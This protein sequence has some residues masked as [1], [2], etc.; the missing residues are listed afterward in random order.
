MEED[1]GVSWHAL[2]GRMAAMRAGQRGFD[3]YHAREPCRLTNGAILSGRERTA[4]KRR[5]RAVRLSEWLAC[6]LSAMA[7]RVHVG[8]QQRVH[9]RLV[10]TALRPKPLNDI[11]IDP[12]RK[13]CFP[14]W[15]GET[16][17]YHS[18]RE[19]FRC[20]FGSVLINYDLRIL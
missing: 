2:D 8:T 13:Q 20:P 6:T 14:T 7:M 3:D 5:R 1:A 12:K 15:R 19:H 16:T 18:P 9:S 10:A 17:P 11:G 4:P